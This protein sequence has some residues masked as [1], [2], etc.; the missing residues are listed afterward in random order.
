MV[1]RTRNTQGSWDIRTHVHRQSMGLAVLNRVVQQVTEHI[2]QY[3]RGPYQPYSHGSYAF[4][5]VF[6]PSA[7]R[8]SRKISD[9]T[10]I[11]VFSVDGQ[12]CA[13][14]I[15]TRNLQQESESIDWKRSNLI[16]QKLQVG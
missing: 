5:L 9:S 13:T 10:R 2:A 3:A 12:H 4:S 8:A 11:E 6:V 14:C 1:K 7:G 15:E 16:V